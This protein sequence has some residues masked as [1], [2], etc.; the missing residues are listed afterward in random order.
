MTEAA[1]SEVTMPLWPYSERNGA[2]AIDDIDVLLAPPEQVL[3]GAEMAEARIFDQGLEAGQVGETQCAAGRSLSEVQKGTSLE[4]ELPFYLGYF[5]TATGQADLLALGIEADSANDDAIISRLHDIEVV[6]EVLDSK[7]R[8]EISNRSVDWH[9]DELSA[10]LARSADTDAE[11]PDLQPVTVNYNPD[12]LLLKLADLQACRGFYRQVWQEVKAM[13]DSPLKRAEQALLEVY[14][15]KTNSMVASLYPNACHLARQLDVMGESGNAERW[16]TEL[17]QVAPVVTR[18]FSSEVQTDSAR[19]QSYFD[20]LC[21][22][23]DLIRNGAAEGEGPDYTPI[24]QG[25]AELA[26]EIDSREIRPVDEFAIQFSPDQLAV[27]DKTVWGSAEAAGFGKDVLREWGILSEH[28]ADWSEVQARDGCAPDGKWQVVVTP[29]RRALAVDGLKKVVWIPEKYSHNLTGVVPA[30]ALPG[31]GHELTHVA[32]N[33]YDAVV[34]QQVSLAKLRGRRFITVREMG[35]ISQERAIQ[36]AFGRERPTNV[37]YLRALQAK[38]AGGSR[39]QAA[40]AF[41]LSATRRAEPGADDA[42][43]RSMA[44]DRVM[45]LYRDGGHDSRPLDYI[46]Q[47]LMSQT[48][49]PMDPERRQAVIIAGGSLSWNDAARL[50]RVG[51]FSLPE[52]VDRDPAADVLRIFRQR[53]LPALISAE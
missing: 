1:Y 18:V 28:E 38:T 4:D 17:M 27:M 19:L 11:M 25:L 30:G 42:K 48:I 23:L 9:K 35:G 3:D 53:Y 13:P 44:A 7:G 33:E 32:Q 34:A 24:S 15:G 14:V 10:Q 21:R 47:D 39:I 12:K 26:D 51:L 22:R 36:A 2:T 5:R 8:K 37:H 41:Y 40:R 20:G 31:M 45:R 46:E 49:E 52:S 29:K 50:H 6:K 43:A 16:S